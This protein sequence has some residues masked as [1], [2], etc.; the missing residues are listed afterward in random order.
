M[1][2]GA[3]KR[4]SKLFPSCSLDYVANCKAA[5]AGDKTA[6]DIPLQIALLSPLLPAPSS[7]ATK[8][9]AHVP[10]VVGFDCEWI[11]GHCGCSRP[12]ELGL[13][14][15]Q[16]Q[17]NPRLGHA[18]VKP[19]VMHSVTGSLFCLGQALI[20]SGPGSLLFCYDPAGA[21]AVWP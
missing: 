8:E 18:A 11:I 4:Q 7:R 17:Q 5:P 6:I 3:L 16:C 9:H 1:C 20:L 19:F 14:V 12:R 21:Q 10:P 13:I 15:W 2:R